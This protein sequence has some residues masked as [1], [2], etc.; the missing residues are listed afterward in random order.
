MRCAKAAEQLQLYIDYQLPF[1]QVR[2]LEKHLFECA[3]CQEEL[4]R[5]EEVTSALR[6]I[7]PVVEPADLTINIMQRVAASE[8]SKKEV[9][10]YKPLRPSLAELLLVLVLATATTLVVITGQPALRGSLPFANTLDS[11]SLALNNILHELISI[12]T[13]TLLLSLWVIGTLLGVCI[14]LAAAGNEMRSLWFKA[15]MDRLSTF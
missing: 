1:E 2:A 9:L 15:M 12:S 3:H 4:F 10:A 11:L 7:S 6:A 8:L 5:M 13:S 14:T